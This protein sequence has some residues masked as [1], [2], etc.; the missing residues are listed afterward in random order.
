MSYEN[1]WTKEATT[2][3]KPTVRKLKQARRKPK[4]Q[5]ER[6]NEWIKT[7]MHKI[8]NRGLHEVVVVGT[9]KS[10]CEIAEA[11]VVNVVER[12]LNAVEIS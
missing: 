7:G 10:E 12:L 11:A 6:G 2:T 8:V 5:R 4:S 1:E 9:E 3:N